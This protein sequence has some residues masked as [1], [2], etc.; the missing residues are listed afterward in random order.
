MFTLYLRIVC[1]RDKGFST[2]FFSAGPASLFPLVQNV[3]MSQTPSPKTKKDGGGG[4]NCKE[5]DNDYDQDRDERHQGEYE[6]EV[7]EEDE[8]AVI[9][10]LRQDLESRRNQTRVAIESSWKEVERPGQRPRTGKNRRGKGGC[11]GQGEER[12][13]GRGEGEGVGRG[14][15]EIEG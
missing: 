1:P 12:C 6:E 7:E 15:G 5:A 2:R 11:R 4:N 3:R 14:Q 8:E 9:T 10:C 13:R